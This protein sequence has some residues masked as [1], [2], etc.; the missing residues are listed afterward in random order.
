MSKDRTSHAA[1]LREFH[2]D[3]ETGVLRRRPLMT[4]A[5]K[6][7][8]DG[9]STVCFGGRTFG[10]HRI[11]WFYVHGKV[12][13]LQIDH[14]NGEKSDNRIANLRLATHSENAQNRKHANVSNRSGLLGVTWIESRQRWGATIDVD[15]KRKYLGR[16]KTPEEAHAAYM[17]AKAELHPFAA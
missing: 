4:P 7:Q 17:A 5:A 12:P 2:Y 13:D 6:K 10:V 9:Y 14:V 11:A 16:F 1:L 8:R 3:P 15:G